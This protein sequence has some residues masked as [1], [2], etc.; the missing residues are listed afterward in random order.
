MHQSLAHRGPD[1]EGALL[2]DGA[3]RATRHAGPV[4]ALPP[5]GALRFG[6]ASHRLAIQDGSAA[7]AQPF[8]SADGQCWVALNGEIYNFAEVRR[9]LTGKG[10]TFRTRTDTEVVLNAY[11][12]WDLDCFRR[13]RGMWAIVLLDLKAGRVVC[14]R[15]RLGIKPLFYS[16]GPHRLLFASEAHAIARALDEARAAARPLREF[17]VGFPP[18]DPEQTFFAGIHA[19]PAGSFAVLPLAEGVPAQLPFRRFWSLP[20]EEGREEQPPFQAAADRFRE[21]LARSVREHS[22]AEAPVGALVS[23]GLD[24][25]TVATLL[26]AVRP[27]ASLKAFSIVFDDPEMTEARYSAQVAARAGLSHWTWTLTPQA[28]LDSLDKVILAQGQPL[29]G[30]DVIAQY[31]AYRLAAEHGVKV[32]LEGQGCDEMLAGMPYYETA[33]FSEYI[34][35]LRLIKLAR[36]LRIRSRMLNR[37][38]YTLTKQYVLAPYRRAFA[39]RHRW[40]RYSWIEPDGAGGATALL[41]GGSLNRFLH[42]LVTQTNLPAVLSFQDRSSMAHGVESRVPFLDHELVEFCFSLPSSYKVDG[43]RRKRLLLPLAADVLPEEVVRRTDKKMF[44]SKWDWL[45]IR[46]ALAGDLLRAVHEGPL[47]AVPWVRKDALQA[48]ARAFLARRH[49]DYLGIWRIV[50]AS[51]WMEA[52]RVRAPVS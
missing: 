9:E 4:T 24:S 45:P 39:D 19:V 25:S 40:R 6:L 14:C 41:P 10:H 12:A 38:L 51:R 3:L 42:R 32:V 33:I 13:F 18:Q 7:G 48:F 47:G 22:V 11:L 50:T 36:E 37:S 2:V 35:R 1:G 44:I 31:H 20:Q 30:Q 26:A 16:L 8:G 46:T 28:C 29:L 52:L 17:L 21:L 27:P 49:N 34:A 23:G 43:G 15:D 5:K